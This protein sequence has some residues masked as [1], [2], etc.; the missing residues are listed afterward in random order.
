MYLHQQFE[1]TKTITIDQRRFRIKF[2]MFMADTAAKND[3]FCIPQTGSYYGCSHCRIKGVYSNEARHVI[4]PPEPILNRYFF[5]SL[6]L[7]QK[8][9]RT[10]E[11]FTRPSHEIKAQFPFTNL[12]PSLP[13]SI[14]LDCMHIVYLGPFRDCLTAII[15][16]Q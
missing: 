8:E 3:V 13:E 14:G 7:E 12:L 2:I 5:Q 4:Y 6:N 16:L 1:A 15:N 10:N 11:D 9:P